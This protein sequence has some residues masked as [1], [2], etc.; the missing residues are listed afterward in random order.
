MVYFQLSALAHAYIHANC[1][2]LM[3][4]LAR[5]CLVVCQNNINVFMHTYRDWIAQIFSICPLIIFIYFIYCDDKLL[6]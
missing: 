3:H 4:V 6:Y 2:A 5:D 1:L